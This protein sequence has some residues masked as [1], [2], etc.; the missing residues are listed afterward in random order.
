MPV[1]PFAARR[2]ESVDGEKLSRFRDRLL[3]ERARLRRRIVSLQGREGD[4]GI[5]K[6]M[7]D[8]TGEISLLDNHPADIGTEVFERG[9]DIKL[10][11]DAEVVLKKIDEALS[12]MDAGDYGGCKR[13][14]REIE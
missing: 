6:S 7:R 5:A 10:A 3:G 8:S 13:C 2:L 9:K 12:R 4:G 11:E 14:G 1:G